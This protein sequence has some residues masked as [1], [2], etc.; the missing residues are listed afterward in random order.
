MRPAG[1]SLP[2]SVL[3][4]ETLQAV[5]TNYKILKLYSIAQKNPN[6]EFKVDRE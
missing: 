2:A 5:A 6:K 1:R 4:E 3:D